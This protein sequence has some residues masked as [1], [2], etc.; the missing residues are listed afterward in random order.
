MAPAAEGERRQGRAAAMIAT[1]LGSFFRAAQDLILPALCLACGERLASSR[2]PLFCPACRE[3]LRPAAS[4]LCS[5]CG[6]PFPHAAGTDH[7]CATCLKSSWHFTRAR[8]LFLYTP[9]VARAIHRLKYDRSTAGLATFRLFF[10]ARR[11]ELA[12]AAFDR[13]VPVPLHPGRLRQRGFNQ[14]L[15]L[16][17]SFFPGDRAVRADLLERSRATPPQTGLSGE[18]RRRNLK[19]AFRAA[20]PQEVDGRTVLLVDDVFTTGATADECAR[21]LRRAGAAEVQVLTLARV[22][23]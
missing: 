9:P 16:A 18:V 20:A 8:A 10:E 11:A 12:P 19:G 23:D 1:G 7:L 4:P 17:R 15:L 22:E 14:A 5:C 3:D 13:I 21:T 2:P 6:R